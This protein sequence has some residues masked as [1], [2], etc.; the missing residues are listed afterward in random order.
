MQRLSLG[1]VAIAATVG[2]VGLVS[3]LPAAGAPKPAAERV[4]SGPPAA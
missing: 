4:R 3:T 1:A 2:A